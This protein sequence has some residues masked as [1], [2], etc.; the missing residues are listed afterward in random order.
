MEKFIHIKADSEI[1]SVNEI[2][3]EQKAVSRLVKIRN[4][5]IAMQK[6]YGYQYP[7]AKLTVQTCVHNPTFF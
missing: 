5:F 1:Y 2:C 6:K 3:P 7:D 4:S